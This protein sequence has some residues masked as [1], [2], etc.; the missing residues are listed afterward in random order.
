[1]YN[2]GQIITQ[3]MTMPMLSRYRFLLDWL[4]VFLSL[5]LFLIKPNNIRSINAH[6]NKTTHIQNMKNSIWSEES[7]Q[8]S[9]VKQRKQASLSMD[10]LSFEKVTLAVIVIVIGYIVYNKR[11]SKLDISKYECRFMIDLDQ[12]VLYQWFMNDTQQNV[13]WAT[14]DMFGIPVDLKK[15]QT[16]PAAI[17]PQRF[18][19]IDDTENMWHFRCGKLLNVDRFHAVLMPKCGGH[20]P[21][22]FGYIECLFVDS[23]KLNGRIGWIYGVYVASE[24]RKNGLGKLLSEYCLQYF[25]SKQIKDVYLSVDDDN[26]AAH[27]LYEKCQFKQD[28]IVISVHEG[29]IIIF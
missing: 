18:P 19:S 2:Y 27:R 15:M 28:R 9:T 17:Y 11:S 26:F 3:H 8:P 22:A 29:R 21:I 10:S 23:Y 24:F 1:M 4:L 13:T 25:H 5:I 6:I 16:G 12:T 14:G 20:D 7:I